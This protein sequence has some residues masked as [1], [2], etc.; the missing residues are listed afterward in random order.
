MA[1]PRRNRVNLEAAPEGTVV[2]A[3]I[4]S[5]RLPPDLGFVR[6]SGFLNTSFGFLLLPWRG[7]SLDH[8]SLGRTDS[9]ERT[10]GVGACRLHQDFLFCGCI[11]WLG[12]LFV[13]AKRSGYLRTFR[14]GCSILPDSHHVIVTNPI[15]PDILTIRPSCSALQHPGVRQRCRF[16]ASFLYHLLL[17]HS[18]HGETYKT[19]S[20]CQSRFNRAC[21]PEMDMIKLLSLSTFISC[22]LRTSAAP[23]DSQC[24][25]SLG[26]GEQSRGIDA[27]VAGSGVGFTGQYIHLDL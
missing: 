4:D 12:K 11:C 2:A 17:R 22:I 10:E 18:N 6:A 19:E 21:R 20:A 13:P 8:V 1:S 9:R 16:S 15:S 7:Y 23:Y 14:K 27:F 3:L 26:T 5:A 25:Y 24:T